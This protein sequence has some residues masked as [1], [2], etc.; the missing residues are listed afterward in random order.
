MT[1][2]VKKRRK[3]QLQQQATSSVHYRLF[4]EMDEAAKQWVLSP[5]SGIAFCAMPETIL[6]NKFKWLCWIGQLYIF[7][8]HLLQFQVIFLLSISFL[9]VIILLLQD[10]TRFFFFQFDIFWLFVQI[11]HTP[12]TI[13]KLKFY[14]MFLCFR[15]M[16]IM[17]GNVSLSTRSSK[18][19]VRIQ[20]A[21]ARGLGLPTHGLAGRHT[22]AASKHSVCYFSLFPSR[23]SCASTYICKAETLAFTV[24]DYC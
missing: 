12:F 14:S 7:S 17:I 8:F 1:W 2:D 6:Y 5:C 19:Y 11:S 10:V 4:R 15:T 21:V 24:C 23:W 9:N 16:K 22:D 3:T 13:N 18:Y 20:T